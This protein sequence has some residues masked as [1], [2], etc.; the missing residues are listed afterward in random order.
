[1]S[2][3]FWLSQ[4]KYN[5]SKLEN[6]SIY[7]YRQLHQIHHTVR[8]TDL[9]PIPIRRMDILCHNTVY[10]KS[11]AHTSSYNKIKCCEHTGVSQP[12]SKKM[13]KYPMMAVSGPSREQVRLY[14]ARNWRSSTRHA[15]MAISCLE[16]AKRITLSTMLWYK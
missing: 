12:L 8:R 9:N 16:T 15:P 13:S 3:W 4:T 7:C 14:G 5:G 1:M 10:Q 2:K 11:V 6:L